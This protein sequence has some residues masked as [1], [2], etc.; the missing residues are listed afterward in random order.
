MRPLR[1]ITN[2]EVNFISK[3]EASSKYGTSVSAS[4]LENVTK[5][6]YPGTVSTVL[7]VASKVR[8]AVEKDLEVKSI[9]ITTLLLA[10]TL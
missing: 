9:A 1:N 5:E 8:A 3:K 6:G 7:S 4:F 2:V 10:I